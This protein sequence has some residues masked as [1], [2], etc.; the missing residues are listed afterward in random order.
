[1]VAVVGVF[2][3]SGC[4]VAMFFGG[5]I[6][7]RQGSGVMQMEQSNQDDNGGGGQH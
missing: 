6:G 5:G 3:G 7:Q 2:D 1:M 4:V